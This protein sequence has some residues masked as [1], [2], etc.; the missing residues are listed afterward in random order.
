MIFSIFF[1]SLF[2]YYAKQKHKPN[3]MTKNL[4]K[5]KEI[6]DKIANFFTKFSPEL[7]SLRRKFH[8]A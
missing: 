7:I 6:K 8:D 3:C 1:N 2:F 5:R 4:S